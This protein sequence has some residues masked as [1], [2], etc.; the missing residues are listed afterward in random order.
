MKIKQVGCL[1]AP[2]LLIKADESGAVEPAPQ[3]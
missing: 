1:V 2:H 3:M